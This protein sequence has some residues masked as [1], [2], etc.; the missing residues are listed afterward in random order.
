M[1]RQPTFDLD[2]VRAAVARAIALMRSQ[3]RLA[4]A[5][6][7]TQA[8]I[9]KARAKGR[10]SPRLA[11]AIHRATAGAVPGSAL[12]PDL[13][14]QPNDVPVEAAW[15]SVE[16]QCAAGAGSAP[17][18]GRHHLFDRIGERGDRRQQS[19]HGPPFRLSE[20]ADGVFVEIMP[21]DAARQELDPGKP[22]AEHL[23]Q[24]DRDDE[25][26]PPPEPGGGQAP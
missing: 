10:L 11:L 5:C 12:R 4:A 21:C 8:V 23:T 14:R 18:Y 20:R 13:W 26:A 9:S 3:Q 16:A 2:L 22:G 6:G 15:A 17:T 19:D 24:V 1:G 7:V 25:R